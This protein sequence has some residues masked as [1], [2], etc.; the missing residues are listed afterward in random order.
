MNVVDLWA[1]P[2]PLDVL[3]W[4]ALQ[5]GR[6]LVWALRT[7]T[8]NV[9]ELGPGWVVAY[10][11]AVVVSWS[12]GSTGSAM[13]ASVRKGNDVFEFDPARRGGSWL[14]WAG[15]VLRF[16]VAWRA[17]LAAVLQLV[18]YGTFVVLVVVGILWRWV[19]VVVIVAAWARWRSL[20][21]RPWWT[22][23]D[24]LVG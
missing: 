9:A 8:S 16:E 21:R 23:G 24:D 6:G 2:A 14:G 1:L 12:A 11:L 15:A 13:G 7:P 3:A 18:G 5:V 10:W 17:Y 22:A 4:C 19:P 20:T